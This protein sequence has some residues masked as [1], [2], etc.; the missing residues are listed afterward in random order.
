[1]RRI[2]VVHVPAAIRRISN[3]SG[4]RNQ[5]CK[6]QRDRASPSRLALL[7]IDPNPHQA[8]GARSDDKVLRRRVIAFARICETRD[9]L[10]PMSAAISCSFSSSK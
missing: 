3:I 2:C 7:R 5:R 8:T 1:M 10:T 4:I 9:S 6:S